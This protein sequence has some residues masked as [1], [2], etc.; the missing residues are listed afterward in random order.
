VAIIGLVLSTLGLM[1]SLGML[2]A[3]SVSLSAQRDL[4][5]RTDGT[6]PPFARDAQ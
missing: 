6:H 4:P 1:L 5:P 2:G 3:M